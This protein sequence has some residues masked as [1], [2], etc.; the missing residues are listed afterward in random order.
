MPRP[1]LSALHT[2]RDAMQGKAREVQNLKRYLLS[3]LFMSMLAPESGCLL[4]CHTLGHPLLPPSLSPN[5]AMCHP[6]LSQHSESK[7]SFPVLGVW[8]WVLSTESLT[9]NFFQLKIIALPWLIP[10][11]GAVL[12]QW[13]LSVEVWSSSTFAST[14][15]NS[16]MSS[17]T[18]RS[19]QYWLRAF[20]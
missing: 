18:Q 20:M 4:K 7:Y 16:E 13:L 9:G 17:H 11:L 2:R 8:G 1:G 12:I 15:V 19:P 14:Q 6:D 10:F 3:G 5:A